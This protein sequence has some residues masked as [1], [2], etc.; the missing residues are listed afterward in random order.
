MQAKGTGAD[1]WAAAGAASNDSSSAARRNRACDGALMAGA[2]T[3][4]AG[5]SVARATGAVSRGA[6][7]AI[8]GGVGSMAGVKRAWT[9]S[10]AWAN[11]VGVISVREAGEARR[12]RPWRTSRAWLRLPLSRK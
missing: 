12:F 1:R 3:K 4:T 10:V 7:S 5:V 2:W 9:A 6:D 8:V 11:T